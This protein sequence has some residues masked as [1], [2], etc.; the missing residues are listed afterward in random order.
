[1]QV[2]GGAVEIS[3][4]GDFQEGTN[5]INFHCEPRRRELS[6]YPIILTIKIRFSNTH[7]RLDFAFR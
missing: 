7:Y 2:F 4:F 1:V 5:M 6:D 3:T